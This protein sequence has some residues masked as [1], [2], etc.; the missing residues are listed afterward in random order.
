ML[1]RVQWNESRNALGSV[2]SN[3]SSGSDATGKNEEEINLR[4]LKLNHPDIRL[5]DKIKQKTLIL[6][7]DALLTENCWIFAKT[8]T[9]FQLVIT[10]T[11]CPL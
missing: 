11:F 7:F 9:F 4:I 10:C 5:K 8:K 3:Q 6:L 2:S 1:G